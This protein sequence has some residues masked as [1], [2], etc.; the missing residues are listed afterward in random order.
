MIMWIII[1][2]IAVLLLLS[3]ASVA[4]MIAYL[5]WHTHGE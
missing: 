4:G 2:V 3:G 5:L 1:L